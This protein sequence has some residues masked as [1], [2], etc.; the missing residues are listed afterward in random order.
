M[1]Q[2]GTPYPGEEDRRLDMAIGE[3]WGWMLANGILLPNPWYPNAGY[4]CVTRVGLEVKTAEDF[5]GLR[6]RHALPREMLHPSLSENVWFTYI[7]GE[8]EAAVMLAFK[9]IEVEVREAAKLG[10]DL[11]GDR[12]IRKAFNEN[13]GPLTDLSAQKSERLNMANFFAGAFGVYAIRSI[14]AAS[15]WMTQ[16]KLPNC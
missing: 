9:E 4:H 6:R 10:D 16:P 5:E 14:T 13:H 15:D 11:Y 1:R 2:H 3:A 12:L 8:M 7:R